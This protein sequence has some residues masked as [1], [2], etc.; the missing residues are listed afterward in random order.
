MLALRAFALAFALLLG[1]PAQAQSWTMPSV[2]AGDPF[3]ALADRPPLPEGFVSVGGLY[4]DVHGDPRDMATVDR[5][6]DHAASAVPRIA[7]RLGLGTGPRMRVVLAK[8]E[9][10]FF[11]MQPGR[12]P[13]WAD[14]TAWPHQALVFLKSPRIRAGT[15]TSLEQVLDH[16]ITHVLLGQAFGNRPVPTWLQE[17]LAQWIAGEYGPETLDRLAKASLAGGLLTLDEIK[18]GFPADPVRANL[19]YAQSADLIAYI[20]S[21]YGEESL[22]V[23]ISEMARGTPVNAAFREATGSFAHELDAA[24]RARLEESSFGLA[25]LGD[26]TL[27]F[28]L[29]A[30]ILVLGWLGVRR[31]NRRRKEAWAEEEARQNAFYAAMR[32]P[33]P[34]ARGWPREGAPNRDPS[35]DG[36]RARPEEHPWV[37]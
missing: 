18:Y 37:H 20:A 2:Q 5:L 4:A 9:A 35:L 34:P 31:R 21:E 33:R 10:S 32:R 11:E 6:A 28:G 29:G 13:S 36:Y 3:A 1:G 24:W 8:D 12:P 26:E 30:P 7:E 23:L 25:A 27:W 22:H 15:A 17:G 19:A 14:G 16:E